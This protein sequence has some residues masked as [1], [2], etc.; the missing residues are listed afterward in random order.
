M[1]NRQL[2]IYLIV[3]LFSAG[4]VFFPSR[5]FTQE[6][7]TIEGMVQIE[8]NHLY[9][10]SVGS[11]AGVSK[12]DIIEIYR[13]DVKVAE[14]RLISVLSVEEWQPL[15]QEYEDVAKGKYPRQNLYLR[16]HGE[17]AGQLREDLTRK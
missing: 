12:G 8:R 5:G 10:I 16:F 6:V 3:F 15:R 1:K 9:M 7:V 11:E 13:I 14:A 4:S 2:V 17:K